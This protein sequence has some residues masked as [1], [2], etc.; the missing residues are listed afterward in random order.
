MAI[1]ARGRRLLGWGICLI[2]LTACPDTG[3]VSPE[4]SGNPSGTATPSTGP[5]VISPSAHPTPATS[6]SPSGKLPDI[7]L[8][9][10]DDQRWDTLWTMPVVRTR[11][12]DRGVEFLNAFASNPVCCPSRATLLTGT[13]SHTN[14][15]FRNQPPDGGFESFDDSSTVATWLSSAG[16]RTA[17]IGKY[18]NGYSEER[19]AYVP[20]GWDRWFAYAS[21]NGNGSFYED[22]LS[23]DG[24]PMMTGHG[25][26]D[27]T[28]RLLADEAV[29]FIEETHVATPLFLYFSVKAPHKPA[30]PAP[31]DRNLFQ[32]LAPYRPPSFNEL[33]VS[34][35]PGYMRK[36]ER[37]TEAEIEEIDDLRKDQARTLV[38]VDRAVG[39]ILDALEATG[40]LQ[41]TLVAFTSD[42][43]YLLGEHR[44]DA[45]SVPYEESIRVPM[46]I[47]FDAMDIAPRTDPRLVMNADLAPTFAAAA[48][49]Q[50][51][52]V[53]GANLLPVVS[54]PGGPWRADFLIEH[55]GAGATYCGVR[56]ER[57]VYVVYST[58]EE[59]LYDLSADP[60]QLDNVAGDPKFSGVVE[61]QRARLHELCNP[62]PPGVSRP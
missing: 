27:Y 35:K 44:R 53:D 13:Y 7:V 52:G 42:N 60:Y 40:R 57:F 32:S 22:T 3:S 2:A 26:E 11:L 50:A 14:G 38:D 55:V 20:P 59:E 28:T 49:L 56:S 62:P 46:V 8:L 21:G 31:G 9:L 12:A 19:V 30:I 24:S 41:T 1:R 37:L 61:E 23:V 51:V 48:G 36:L 6:G 29:A 43:G 4:G 15:V 10:T 17:L 34:D 25:P 39:R 47:R 45:K 16:Y 33:D 5:T 54:S 58:E 18:L